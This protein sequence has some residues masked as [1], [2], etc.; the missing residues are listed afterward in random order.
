MCTHQWNLYTLCGHYEDLGEYACPRYNKVN[1][2]CPKGS[3]EKTRKIKQ[4]CD[5]CAAAEASLGQ[6]VS[7]NPRRSASFLT[8]RL[9]SPLTQ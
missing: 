9:T 4:K 6:N 7:S 8:A 3:V 5:S 1:N 2:T